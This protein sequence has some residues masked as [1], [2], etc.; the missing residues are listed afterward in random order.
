MHARGYDIVNLILIDILLLELVIQ[1]QFFDQNENFQ[2]L[3]ISN[4]YLFEETQ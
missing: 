1:F 2:I 3:G 4:V